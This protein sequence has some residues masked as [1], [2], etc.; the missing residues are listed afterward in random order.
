[1]LHVKE[2]R[3]CPSSKC[4]IHPS[5]TYKLIR[6]PIGHTN[7]HNPLC[8]SSRTVPHADSMCLCMCTGADKAD[9]KLPFD[10][11]LCRCRC[12]SAISNSPLAPL[13]FLSPSSAS[14]FFVPVTHKDMSLCACYTPKYNN[15]CAQSLTHNILIVRFGASQIHTHALFSLFGSPFLSFSVSVLWLFLYFCIKCVWLRVCG[16]AVFAL[17]F[18]R[19]CAGGSA[20]CCQL[21]T[22]PTPRAQRQPAASTTHIVTHCAKSGPE[23]GVCVHPSPTAA[24][25]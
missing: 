10:I 7:K 19:V 11:V 4:R 15:S 6:N 23:S 17:L 20:L 5:L 21:G 13:P 12:C 16:K 24:Q 22:A 8:R 1:M 9:A 25:L 3:V 2:A 18:L 14:S